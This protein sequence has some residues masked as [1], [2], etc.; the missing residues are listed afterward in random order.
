M[1]IH[2][3][4]LGGSS[5]GL[6]VGSQAVL[7]NEF[8]SSPGYMV[9]PYLK[10][11]NKQPKVQPSTSP[12]KG[13]VGQSVHHIWAPGVGRGRQHSLR[14]LLESFHLCVCSI[15]ALPRLRSLGQWQQV[16]AMATLFKQLVSV[17][18]SWRIGDI[19]LTGLCWSFNARIRPA[20]QLKERKWKQ[21]AGLWSFACYQF[22]TWVW[23]ER[24]ETEE[25]L[26]WS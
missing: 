13:Y 19:D 18:A 15:W 5:R 7:N 3:C 2:A 21:L 10:N 17:V 23:R 4:T 14:V 11:Q 20:L 24:K 1:V 16:W 8:T 22:C 12:T 9:R 6:W 26:S 25:E